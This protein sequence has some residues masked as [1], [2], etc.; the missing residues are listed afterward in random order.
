MRFVI[1]NI[2]GKAL[3]LN[4]NELC[5]LE[6][7][8]KCS[9]SENAKGWY[10]SILALADSMP[11]KIDHMTVDR[12]VKKL[13]NMGLIERKENKSLYIAQNEKSVAQIETP[14][15]QN[16]NPIAQNEKPIA[17]N[18]TNSAPLNN[19]P[20]ENI[21]DLQKLTETTPCVHATEDKGVI[22]MN[23]PFESFI[24]AFKPTWKMTAERKADL[25]YKWEH[26]YS[27]AK[28][29][30]IMDDLYAHEAA[31]ILTDL[32]D[33]LT[34]CEKFEVPAPYD[35]NGDPRGRQLLL[36]G[37]LATAAWNGHFGTYS[38][39]DIEIYGLQRPPK[40]EKKIVG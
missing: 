36:E 21:N 32:R 1:G 19:P 10:G 22:F 39:E 11:F 38:V 2:D 14:I 5:V 24:L 15:A 35:W 7:I 28:K 33:P 4:A 23:Y 30:F 20:I 16:E 34:Y 8:G 12:A 25:R 27:R 37:K 17:Q 13:L 40:E 6:A 3:G 29:K 31:N 18:E 9:R 26:E